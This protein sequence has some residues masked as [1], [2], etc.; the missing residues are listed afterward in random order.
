MASDN[1]N[2][3]FH[4]AFD[5]GTT[6]MKCILFDNDFNEVKKCAREYSLIYTA[7]TAELDAEVYYS[8]FCECTREIIN[9]GIQP[10]SIK[11]VTFTTQGETFVCVDKSGT[12]LQRAI[13]WL[14][15]RAEKEAD[16]IIKKFGKK[17][18]YS[19]TGLWQPDGALPLAKLMHIKKH[20][21]E[22]YDKTYK[23]LLLED[24]LIMKLTGKFVTEKSLVS[25][26]GWYDII[27]NEYCTQLF[28]LCDIDKSKFP[29]VLNC[30]TIVSDVKNTECGLTDK[31]AVVTGAMDQICS[32][33]GAGNVYDGCVTETTGTALVVG[34]TVTRP[35]F[36]VNT[37]VTIY[38]HFNE[39]YIYMPYCN[40]A[41]IVLKWFKDTLGA[42]ICYDAEK[43]GIPSYKMIDKYAVNSPA[44]SNGLIMLA[45]FSGK[46]FPDSIPNA[47]G[48]FFGISLSTTICDMSR[49]VLEG[50][51]YML[52]E[53]VETLHQKGMDIKEIKSLGGGS[54]SELWNKIKASVCNCEIDSNTYSETTALGAAILGAVAYGEYKDVF[55]AIK[56]LPANQKKYLPDSEDAKVYKKYYEKYKELYKN[57]KGAF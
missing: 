39:N 10:Q 25:S 24:Y 13:V 37:P 20:L 41:G 29:D 26:T 4:L 12:P 35:D 45:H 49:S 47:K 33:I 16:Y 23:F 22:I 48:V 30:G 36:D 5:V 7:N 18:F 40:T 28:K 53:T 44:G 3:V 43:L 32:A 2:A 15:A 55:E 11:D 19:V 46:N 17:E 34:A 31:C 1:K 50:V 52:K 38:K 6:A 8:T 42:K 56:R 51:A 57:L 9:G 21:S 14:D 54:A 27:N